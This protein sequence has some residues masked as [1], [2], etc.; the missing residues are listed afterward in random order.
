MAESETDTASGI[1]QGKLKETVVSTTWVYGLPKEKLVSLMSEMGLDASGTLDELRKRFSKFLK[2][3]KD[4]A[5]R[6][7]SPTRI[8][9]FFQA[10]EP[11]TVENIPVCEKVRKWGVSYDGIADGISFLERVRELQSCYNIQRKDLLNA[12]P[13]LLKDEA[14]L[15]YRNNKTSWM[16][17]EDFIDDFKLQYF[18]ARYDYMIEEQIR[19]RMQKPGELFKDYSTALLTLFRRGK[20]VSDK[21]QLE[22][23]YN[24]MLPDYKLYARRDTFK[25]LKDLSILAAEFE[26]IRKEQSSNLSGR[27]TFNRVNRQN[28][29]TTSVPSRQNE[30]ATKRGNDTQPKNSE[31]KL[32]NPEER[33]WRCSQKGHTRYNCRRRP[34]LFCS[35]CGRLQ[36]SS[37]NC[38][39]SKLNSG[40]LKG[41]NR[42]PP[43]NDAHRRKKIV[44]VTKSPD[45]RMYL[46]ISLFS[47][48]T[49][50]LIDSGATSSLISQQVIDQL[51]PAR[52]SKMK[53]SVTRIALANGDIVESQARVSL[54]IEL[55]GR[56]IFITFIVMPQ[57]SYR[58]I[59]GINAL[60]KLDAI[61]DVNKRDFLRH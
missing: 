46:N 38:K 45:N 10:P 61:I 23:L 49:C 11:R 35:R 14:L 25:T 3:G 54:P 29:A 13:L 5:S 51:P 9:T 24:N 55:P 1:S 15:W 57:N 12:L 21:D 31:N 4:A 16:Q 27:D 60:K 36:I 52:L 32:S 53:E 43:Q 26:K 56:T 33:C 30:N 28:V 39:C 37:R 40:R 59:L 44:L 20:R 42:P 17:W 8:D 18:P 7:S 22:R 2:I 50:A 47:I 19:A 58:V 41:R 48:S 34:V 6:T